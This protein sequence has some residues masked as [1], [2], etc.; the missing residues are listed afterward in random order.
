MHRRLRATYACAV[1][2]LTALLPQV[3]HAYSFVPT[4]F[5][6]AGWPEYCRA[7]YL[8][9]DIGGAQKW[10]RSYSQSVITT[11]RRRIGEPSFLHV[12]HYCAGLAWM[13]RAR[14]ESQPKLK[15][16]YLGQANTEMSYTYERI[17]ESS[18]IYPSVAVNL[19]RVVADA[20]Q[21][22]EAVTI[23]E[24]AISVHPQDPR[25]YIGLSV[26]YRDLKQLD[27]ARD[28]LL[29]GDEAVGGNSVEI[30]YTLGLV[31][32]ELKDFDRSVEFA[33]KAYARNYPLP[34][35][36]DKLRRSGHWP[37]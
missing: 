2:L 5:E 33:Q 21:P 32:F 29:K 8:T 22:N 11:E 28:A 9:T 4:D 18:P 25:P 17:P 35:L 16:S 30:H 31:Y 34:G 36:Q 20:G 13:S 24:H 7:R 15:E 23:I 37:G 6:W 26:L 1:L 10:A 19:A 12:H 14:S 27:R 3:G